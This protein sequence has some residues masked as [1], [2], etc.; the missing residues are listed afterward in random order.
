MSERIAKY[1]S[2]HLRQEIVKDLY[3][4]LVTPFTGEASRYYEIYQTRLDG[5]VPPGVITLAD[6]VQT[7]NDLTNELTLLVQE[8]IG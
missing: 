3:Y 4:H 1:V 2:N 7:I 5:Y 8:E 6:D